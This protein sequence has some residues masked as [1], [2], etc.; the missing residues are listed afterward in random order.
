[1]LS[2]QYQNN[3]SFVKLFHSI[4]ENPSYKRLTSCQRSVLLDIFF[5]APTIKKLNRFNGTTIELG[6]GQILTSIKSIADESAN[7][8]SVK[9]V[10][11]AI[12]KFE[13]MGII[14]T[15]S[16]KK[17]GTLIT[18]V[19]IKSDDHGA[20]V[21]E[22]R[23]AKWGKR[24]GKGFEHEN[25]EMGQTEI[26]N[27]FSISKKINKNIDIEKSKTRETEPATDP[28][29]FFNNNYQKVVQEFVEVMIEKKIPT[30][31][32]KPIENKSAYTQTLISDLRKRP[33][34]IH[35]MIKQTFE[36]KN[37]AYYRKRD[38]SDY[39]MVL[40]KSNGRE[41]LCRSDDPTIRHCPG[42]ATEID[43]I[44]ELKV[45]TPDSNKLGNM[46]DISYGSA[47]KLYQ[48]GFG[49]MANTVTVN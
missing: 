25:S 20:K 41:I 36:L 4:K 15:L 7:D 17:D 1:M 32:G 45:G 9:A 27:P 43:Y 11:V 39:V 26:E 42:Y 3:G 48:D 10:R 38:L 46:I 21:F 28:T 33:G 24:W 44:R 14:N 5:M 6:Y 31:N 8:V 30:K 2:K 37:K 40:D 47:I 19:S 35:R 13:K 29:T 22:P 49:V 12:K 16:S 34:E 23:I 18:I